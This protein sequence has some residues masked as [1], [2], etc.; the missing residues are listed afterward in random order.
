MFKPKCFSSCFT[1]VRWQ[2][3]LFKFI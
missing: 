3:Y 2:V 1:K